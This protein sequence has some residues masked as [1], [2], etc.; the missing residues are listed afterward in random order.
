MTMPFSLKPDTTAADVWPALLAHLLER[1]D[2]TSDAA[3]WAMR[4][5]IQGEVSSVQLAAFLT[6]L[7]AKGETVGEVDG[8]VSALLRAAQP[9]QVAGPT[10]DIAGTGG[11]GTNAV[12]I[13]TMAA[14]VAAATGVR[15]VKHGG[16]AATATTA[17]SADLVQHLG[18]PLDLPPDRLAA[19][20]VQAGI[21]FLWAPRMHPGMRHAGPVRRELGVPT[22]FNLL[23]PL[24]NPASPTHRVVGVADPRRLPVV[25]EVLRARGTSALVVRGD[26]GLDKLSTT[27]TSQAWIV[28]D[29]QASHETVDPRALHLPC[30]SPGALRGGDAQANARILH[31]VFAGQPGPIRNAVVLNAAAALVAAR[32]SG[33]TLVEH[34]H[35]ASVRCGEAIDSGAAS[36][37]LAN[38]ISIANAPPERI[39]Q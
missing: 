5:V 29:G 38:W 14:V 6:A 19:I 11:D 22:V 20:A 23:G 34:L 37:T 1:R 10:L 31:A 9:V 13:S 25:V 26:D 21:T 24:I 32:P 28:R 27:T 8:F 4:Q 3:A 2:L 30:P 7:R 15:V 16:R 18:I 33:S 12:N 17:G 35:T 36:A 39:R